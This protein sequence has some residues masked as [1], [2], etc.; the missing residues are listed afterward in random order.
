M[1]IS[2]KSSEGQLKIHGL[3]NTLI[4]YNTPVE[5]E[6]K[7]KRIVLDDTDSLQALVSFSNFKI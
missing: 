3:E 6:Q 7:S 4:G 1:E 2:Q 5:N